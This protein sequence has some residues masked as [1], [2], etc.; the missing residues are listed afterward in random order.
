MNKFLP[1][2]Y[3]FKTK[4]SQ[5]NL[6]F[7][8]NFRLSKKNYEN[9]KYTLKFLQNCYLKRQLSH[10]STAMFPGAAG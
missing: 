5:N 9:L 2:P 10:S 7:L 6:D 1:K 8:Y 3:G 4:I